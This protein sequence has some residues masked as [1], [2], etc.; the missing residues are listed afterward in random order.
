MRI[1]TVVKTPNGVRNARYFGFGKGVTFY[2]HTA[3]IWMP[4]GKQQ[5]ISTNESEAFEDQIHRASC[6]HLIMAAIASWNAV[7]LS[8]AVEELKK[9][10]ETIPDRIPAPH[11]TAGLGAY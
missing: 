11:Y 6:L 4:F 9:R 7:Y 1:E 10:G 2:S 5:V 3:D 8:Q